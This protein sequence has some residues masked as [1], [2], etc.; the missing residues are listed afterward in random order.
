MALFNLT[1]YSPTVTEKS[2]DFLNNAAS[3]VV[4]NVINPVAARLGIA[5]LIPG[6]LFGS[7]GGMAGPRFKFKGKGGDDWRVKISLGSGADVLYK[8]N[9]NT[10]MKPLRDTGVIFPYTPKITMTH[11]ANYGEDSP[12]HSNYAMQF[13]KNSQVQEIQISGEFTVQN[14][15]EGAYVLAVIYFFRAATKMF[16]GQGNHAGNPPPLVFLDGLGDHYLPHVPCVITSFSHDM[17]QEVDFLEVIIP[18]PANTS[19]SNPLTSCTGIFGPSGNSGGEGGMAQLAS[20]SMNSLGQMGSIANAAGSFFG[21]PKSGALASP[22]K[23]R[24]PTSSTITIGL[25]P[26]YSRSNMANR[27]DLNK[28]ANGD[29]LGNAKGNVGGF[30]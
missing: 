17:P 4:D 13:Y 30:I 1:D 9:T 23:T 20:M 24:I 21:A 8:D 29:L 25:K 16:F 28:F 3:T 14:N 7:S 2:S 11:Q 10:L 22:T 15:A 27:F 12:T 18:S 19:Q 5:G 26:V 6:G